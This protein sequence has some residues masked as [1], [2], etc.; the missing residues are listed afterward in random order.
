M[1]AVSGDAHGWAFAMIDSLRADIA[2]RDATL[3]DAFVVLD[4]FGVSRRETLH[5]KIQYLDSRVRHSESAEA[6]AAW[7]RLQKARGR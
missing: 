6:L 3:R 1:A 4:S 5:A 2:A 7:D